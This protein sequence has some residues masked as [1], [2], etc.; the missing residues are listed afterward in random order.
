MSDF[1]NSFIESVFALIQLDWFAFP[2]IAFVGLFAIFF[3]RY[4]VWGK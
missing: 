1:L 4:V 2:F 3:I